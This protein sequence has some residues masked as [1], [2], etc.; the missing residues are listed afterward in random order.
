MS[1]LKNSDVRKLDELRLRHSSI[2]LISISPGSKKQA[3]EELLKIITRKNY[4][5]GR[6]QCRGHILRCLGKYT[7]LMAIDSDHRFDLI[8]WIH[9]I[10]GVRKISAHCGTALHLNKDAFERKLEFDSTGVGFLPL[11]A[12]VFLKICNHLLLAVGSDLIQIAKDFIIDELVDKCNYKF[13]F[14]A[15]N[16]FSIDIYSLEG[17][18]EILCIIRTN[19]HDLLH[20]ICF[21][22]CHTIDFCEILSRRKNRARVSLRTYDYLNKNFFNEN[23]ECKSLFSM[24]ISLEGF[25]H[26]LMY[27]ASEFMTDFYKQLSPG[28]SQSS[29]NLTKLHLEE[30]IDY[31]KIL[32][33]IRGKSPVTCVTNYRTVTG[34]IKIIASTI[35]QTFSGR[36]SD[37]KFPKYHMISPQHLS[38]IAR[39]N[40]I[41]DFFTDFIKEETSFQ[42]GDIGAQA[43]LYST[44]TSLII[45]YTNHR[46]LEDCFKSKRLS[47]ENK[48]DVIANDSEFREHQLKRIRYLS[49]ATYNLL[50]NMFVKYHRCFENN[51]VYLYFLSMFRYMENLKK[52]ITKHFDKSIS[53]FWEILDD[54]FRNS[55][56]IN[57]VELE[58][59]RKKFE[60]LK[61]YF[62][63]AALFFE[64][65][66]D[67]FFSN[68]Y[69]IG[70]DIDDSSYGF[71]IGY[72]GNLLEMWGLFSYLLNMASKK[73][74][75]HGFCLL[76]T[77]DSIEYDPKHKIIFFPNNITHEIEKS[78]LLAHEAGHEVLEVLH[79]GHIDNMIIV[80]LPE[81]FIEVFDIS[82]KNQLNKLCT[83][84]LGQEKVPIIAS[85][86]RK[87]IL[88]GSASQFEHLILIDTLL[89][90]MQIEYDSNKTAV[91]KLMEAPRLKENTGLKGIYYA[92]FDPESGPEE[93]QLQK[94][95]VDVKEWRKDQWVY[96]DLTS[97]K[98]F[99]IKKNGQDFF[100]HDYSRLEN[101]KEKIGELHELL[102]I[103]DWYEESLPD[104]NSQRLADE[105][106]RSEDDNQ[107]KNDKTEKYFRRINDISEKIRQSE[108]IFK[109]FGHYYELYRD[110]FCDLFSFESF[111]NFPF[112]FRDNESEADDRLR[113]FIIS[114][115]HHIEYPY[116]LKKDNIIQFLYRAFCVFSYSRNT[117]STLKHKSR[118]FDEF[119]S[120]LEDI[121]SDPF[122]SL[123][124]KKFMNALNEPEL[125][126]FVTSRVHQAFISVIY[127][128]F[129]TNLGKRFDI[130]SAKLTDADERVVDAIINSV[131]EL[132]LSYR[133]RYIERVYLRDQEEEKIEFRRSRFKLANIK[134]LE[135]T[136]TRNDR[137][138]DFVQ[139]I[140]K[141]LPALDEKTIIDNLDHNRR[142]KIRVAFRNYSY[143]KMGEL[144][145]EKLF[146]EK[147]YP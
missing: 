12:F 65:A 16:D 120:F 41:T 17:A 93:S 40:S 47:L 24:S 119:R 105:E 55:S 61:D 43:P 114:H 2:L 110:I 10:S 22:I 38:C 136:D 3:T 135:S 118:S 7:L 66:Y 78:F 87:N 128:L 121:E 25:S 147:L 99:I 48:F 109:I 46:Q 73:L 115:F 56:D 68:S 108:R 139:W 19:D 64:M 30:N 122:Y 140:N 117:D 49:K 20:K 36:Y 44:E 79:G 21:C 53:N 144:F 72:Q 134:N 31:L 32:K 101:N 14:N 8:S 67:Q 88:D 39:V 51:Q 107:S 5:M 85:Q 35:D 106:I 27:N 102:D 58:E 81:I 71:I 26:Q 33:L 116:S 124:L 6:K 29:K 62:Q 34:N 77:K 23:R 137:P 37:N 70:T 98:L 130:N 141:E 54:D 15:V 69:A 103:I 95:I 57:S 129:S 13:G 75:P 126:N 76:G 82:F 59:N 84:N 142:D 94:G 90:I 133:M 131:K 132:E 52:E 104:S 50:A 63:E 4:H 100:V 143:I 89:D 11:G 80:K 125:L 86:I 123:T 74:S 113:R 28:S 138:K 18:Y 112:K 97:T 145:G 9:H 60:S 91:G 127:H 83:Y 92:Q 1:K 45:D 111:F 96:L 42:R 146:S